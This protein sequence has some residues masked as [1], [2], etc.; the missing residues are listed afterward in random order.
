MRAATIAM[1]AVLGFSAATSH[2]ASITVVPEGG[3]VY[4][5]EL[6]LE[7]GE[8]V[9]G[10]QLDLRVSPETTV[11]VL[12][13][14]FLVPLTLPGETWITNPWT[15]TSTVADL[16]SFNG[17]V[18]LAHNFD[19]AGRPAAGITDTHFFN[20]DLD[21]PDGAIPL[22]YLQFIDEDLGPFA[23][24]RD[25]SYE[26]AGVPI[27]RLGLTGGPLPLQWEAGLCDAASIGSCELPQSGDVRDVPGP[28]PRGLLAIALALAAR[29]RWLRRSV[30][31]SGTP[32]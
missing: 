23:S 9:Q 24:F 7:P 22:T 29:G 4:R 6:I 12:E 18:R 31:S 19:R 15:L 16:T 1:A 27:A 28:D 13:T 32:G 5:Y 14:G 26:P 30:R 17:A 21:D 10:I 20:P 3:D 11:A 25:P 2:G 8:A